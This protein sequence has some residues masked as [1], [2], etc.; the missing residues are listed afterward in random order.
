MTTYQKYNPE[1]PTSKNQSNLYKYNELKNKLGI[2]KEKKTHKIF[3]ILFLL[4]S[5]LAYLKYML[6]GL[7]FA[8]HE[9]ADGVYTNV[10][11]EHDKPFW[12]SINNLAQYQSQTGYC[13]TM[14]I[15]SSLLIIIAYIYLNK[16]FKNLSNAY[17]YFQWIVVFG[18][19][20]MTFI[21]TIYGY[22]QAISI[23]SGVISGHFLF[24][25]MYIPMEIIKNPLYLTLTCIS[26][27]TFLSPKFVSDKGPEMMRE[28]KLLKMKYEFLDEIDRYK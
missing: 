19:I 3:G 17:Q 12:V 26:L 8:H 2:P 20:I 28:Q 1:T 4:I 11:N 5:I 24:S 25:L 9:K 18:L 10:I 6:S 14:S 21:T 22:N 23:G 7:W 27:N 13:W 16:Q 15:F